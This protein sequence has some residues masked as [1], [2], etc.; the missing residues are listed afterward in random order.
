MGAKAP[1]FTRSLRSFRSLSWGD[2]SSAE[3]F[4]ADLSWGELSTLSC[5]PSA[6]SSEPSSLNS[7]LSALGSLRAKTFSPQK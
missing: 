2:H 1:I 3:A 4:I 6:L 5:Q 7:R